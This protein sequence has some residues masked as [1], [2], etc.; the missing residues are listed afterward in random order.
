GLRYEYVTPPV[1]EEL[2]HV[3]GFDFNTGKQLFPVLGQIRKSIINPDHLNFAPRLGLAWNPE[4]A[5]SFT[6]RAGAGIYFDQTQMNETQFTTNSPPT[7]FQQNLSYTGQGLPPAQFGVNTLPVVAVPPISASYVTPVGTNLFAEELRGR[8]PR[9]YMWNL[10]IQKSIGQNWLAEVAYVVS[11]SRLLSKRYNSDAPAV[12]GVLYNVVPGAQPFP[13]LGG[14]L[15]SSESGKGNYNSLNTK[16]ERRFSAGVSILLAY[17]WSHSIDTDS[18]GSYGSP[19]LNPANFQLDKGSSD[20]DIRH[21]FVGS[22]LYELPFGRGKKILG[23]AS[24]ALNQLIGGWQLNLIPTLQSGVNRNVTSPNTSTIAYVTQHANAIGIDPYSSFSLKGAT[25]TPRE[26]FGS[27]NRSLYWFNPL[28]FTQAAP[29]TF[30]TAGRDIIASPGFMNWDI[31]LFKTF[32]L[33]EGMNLTFRAEFFDAFN[34]VRFDPP[35]LDASSPFFGQIQSAQQ[36]RIIQLG[37][38]LQF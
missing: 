30:G 27:N 34:Q 35:N 33:R 2:N 16:L 14:M 29:L 15:Y 3:F 8:K 38:R 21:R 4:W 9:E 5:R 6:I 10:S 17:S 24:G 12:P 11:Q 25:I 37:L 26:G 18:G 23:S 32:V 13:N 36:P 19:N 7:F 28:A 22:V 20:F 31:S 1:A